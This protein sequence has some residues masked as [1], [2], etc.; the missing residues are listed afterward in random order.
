MT[1]SFWVAGIA[2]ATLFPSIAFAQTTCEQQHERR[3]AG[4]VIGGIAGALLGNAVSHGGGRTGGTLLGAAAGAAVGNQV[5]RPDADCAHAY[6]YYDHEGRWHANNVQ[7]TEARGYYDRDG[8]WMDGAPS[9]HYAPDG[10]WVSA[11]N[12]PS[13]AGYTDANGRWVPASS[14][15]YYDAEGVWI[16]GA[17]PGRYDGEGRWVQGPTTGSYDENGRWRQGQAAGRMDANGVWV[18]DPHPG[19]WENGQWRRGQASGYYDAG[20]RWIATEDTAMAPA[21]TYADNASPRVRADHW[22]G[23]DT[24]TREQWLSGKIQRLAASGQIG[25]YESRRALRTL[26]AI[27]RDDARLRDGGDLNEDARMSIQGRLDNLASSLRIDWQD[28]HGA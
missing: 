23:G 11:G 6:G 21:R 24:R 7:A 3:V 12:D 18:A 13:A 10:R 22:N 28:R 9:G 2:V 15:G 1:K 5:T 17:A 19:R 20:G 27:Q 25:R 4:T 14:G 26:H 8:R 16:A